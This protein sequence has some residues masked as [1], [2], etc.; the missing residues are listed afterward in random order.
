VSF[1]YNSFVNFELFYTS[2]YCEILFFQL[3]EKQGMETINWTEVKV[4]GHV[5]DELCENWEQ[6]YD[7]KPL[8]GRYKMCPDKISCEEACQT[9]LHD[10]CLPGILAVDTEHYNGPKTSTWKNWQQSLKF[11]PI[12]QYGDPDCHG[13][14]VRL[15]QIASVDGTAMVFDLKKLARPGQI[16]TLID[17]FRN[18]DVQWLGHALD[19]D[20]RALA[21][22]DQRLAGLRMYSDTKMIWD[23]LQHG[24]SLQYLAR[25]MNLDEDNIDLKKIGIPFKIGR[26][27]LKSVCEEL[28]NVSPSKESQGRGF[29]WAISLP[30]SDLNYAALDPIITMDIY[31][32]INEF[33]DS[34]DQV[35]NI[36]KRRSTETVNILMLDRP[37]VSRYVMFNSMSVDVIKSSQVG[38]SF[39]IGDVTVTIDDEIMSDNET[40]QP[41]HLCT[42]TK[43]KPASLSTAIKSKSSTAKLASTSDMVQINR[44]TLAPP[45]NLQV[46]VNN[47]GSGSTQPRP[48]VR[49]VGQNSAIV[50][51]NPTAPQTVVHLPARRPAVVVRRMLTRDMAI[52]RAYSQAKSDGTRFR[53]QFRNPTR[54]RQWTNDMELFYPQCVSIIRHTFGGFLQPDDLQ[55]VFQFLKN[56]LL[57]RGLW[58]ERKEQRKQARKRR[59]QAA[60]QLLR[61]QQA[62][63][64]RRNRPPSPAVV[65]QRPVLLIAPP[66]HAQQNDHGQHPYLRPSFTLPRRLPPPPPNFR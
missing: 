38:D 12:D 54:Y 56:R 14:F 55:P 31:L 36:L 41:I 35:R 34:F 65:A 25:K 24:P 28:L 32:R 22:T 61:Q 30:E 45:A 39:K 63:V 62:V 64:A 20:I 51:A 26:P 9:S 4:D 5:S 27:G 48:L 46:K 47:L 15:T 40:E 6:N 16:Q 57:Q 2:Y 3:A 23:V 17:L 7:R 18:E 43:P 33:F 1:C 52:S 29:S 37:L 44:A 42:A 8:R 53:N 59:R 19:S 11:Y 49:I 50:Q 60:R 58:S 10:P 21:K 66:V 13:P